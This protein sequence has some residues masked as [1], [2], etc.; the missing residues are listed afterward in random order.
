MAFI[1]NKNL[2]LIPDQV[3]VIPIYQAEVKPKYELFK[4]E[5][6]TYPNILNASAVSYFPGIRG[7]NQN[8]WWEGLQANDNSNMMNWIPA[9]QD[10]LK[11]LK[12]ELVKGENFP[13]RISSDGQ[14]PYVLNESAA[15]KI[16]WDNPLGKQFEI[17]GIKRKGK[18]VGIVKDFNFESLHNEIEPAAIVFYPDLFDNLMI[19]IST[20][21]IPGTLDFIRE[22]WKSLFLQTPFEYSF[23]SDDFQKLYEKEAITLK[24]VTYVSIIALFISCIGLFGLVLF[25]IDRR[26]K[27]IGLRKVAGSTSSG[28]LI[29]LN[30]EFIKW[31]VASFIISCPIIIYLMHRWLENFAYRVS[32]KWWMFACAGLITIIISLITISWHALSIAMKNPAECLK[33]E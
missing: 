31:I 6:L 1:R 10:F 18:V 13:E 29:M 2:G 12:I 17:I 11:T 16:G 3:M 22:K 5:I 21:N 14:N 8:A 33:H 24:I 26:T 20:E 25:T 28:I 30:V 19:K 9:D 7:Y 23:L 4:K 32:L 27:E 15:K